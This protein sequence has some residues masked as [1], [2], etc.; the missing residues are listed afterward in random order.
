MILFM[1]GGDN[2]QYGN[3]PVQTDEYTPRT[4]G[5]PVGGH[6]SLMCDWPT[7]SGSSLKL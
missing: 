7:G 4:L 1:N 6:A 2:E 5:R 3:F